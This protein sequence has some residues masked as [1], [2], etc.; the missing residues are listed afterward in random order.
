MPLKN[1]REMGGAAITRELLA[2]NIKSSQLNQEFIDAGRGHERPSEILKMSDP[3]AERYK[4][5]W[6]RCCDLRA[7]AQRRY[8]PDYSVGD[9]L[10]GPLKLYA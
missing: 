1:P 2:L 8:G 4:A 10:C 6:D 5:Q 3:L 7:E 9:K